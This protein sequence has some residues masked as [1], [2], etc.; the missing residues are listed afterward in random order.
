MSGGG[1]SFFS[2]EDGSDEQLKYDDSAFLFFAG[3]ALVITAVPYGLYVLG[4]I[5]KADVVK[6]H[7]HTPEGTVYKR[8]RT[9]LT[10]VQEAK[11]LVDKPSKWTLGLLVHLLLLAS[12]LY[13]VYVCIDAAG[14]VSEIK[15]FDPF[16]ILGV[17]MGADAKE[18]KKAYRNLSLKWHPDKNQND[19]LAAATFIQITKAYNSLTDEAAKANFEKYG[20]PDGPTTMKVSVGLPAFL[21]EQDNQVTTLVVFFLVLFILLP[22]VFFC[23]FAR[24]QR[25][26]NNGVFVE[27]MQIISYHLREDT[28]GP[29]LPELIA[30][31]EES[32]QQS[33]HKDDAKYMKAVHDAVDEHKKPQ[34]VRPPVLVRNRALV[35]A[36]LQRKTDLLSP[37]LKKDLDELLGHSLLITETMVDCA[38]SRNW[39]VTA[40]AVIEFRRCLVQALDVKDSQLLQ[41]PHIDQGL[42]KELQRGK[43]K[44]N[45]VQDFLATPKE[46]RKA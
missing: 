21:L 28:R 4:R 25:Y 30:M 6:S 19:P 45:T 43:K 42:L 7:T 34:F 13:G 39:L 24:Q 16:E 33:L 31:M 12:M 27:S 26:H 20:N 38:M 2:K 37:E 15:S 40:Q 5:F 17:S 11:K 18:I 35:W 9:T 22:C 41:I 36:H 8:C 29:Q 23:N 14:S 32:R 1:K 44:A 3:A 10:E 46:E